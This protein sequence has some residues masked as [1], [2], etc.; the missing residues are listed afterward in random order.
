[1]AAA[2]HSAPEVPLLSLIKSTPQ[3]VLEALSTIGFIHLDLDGT[4]LTQEDVD[5]AF[6]LSRLLHGVPLEHRAGLGLDARGNGYMPMKGSLDERSSSVDFKEG[7]VWGRFKSS[8][9][10]TQTT[11]KLPDAVANLRHEIKEFDNRCFEASLRVLDML[12]QAL[13]VRLASSIV[14]QLSY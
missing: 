5:R 14:L 12:S 11:Q 9:G 3:D 10:E 4:G 13:S 2:V 1:M 6:Q 7:Y 8:S